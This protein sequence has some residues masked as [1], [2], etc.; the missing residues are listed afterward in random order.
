M[1]RNFAAV[2]LCLALLI[3]G[4]GQKLAPQQASDL[5][6]Q[7]RRLLRQH[8]LAGEIAPAQWPAAI[9]ALRPER[10]YVRAEGLYIRKSSFF[11]T[12]GG[13]FV[14]ASLEA[15]FGRAGD[16]AYRPIAEGVYAYRIEG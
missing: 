10:V 13:Y 11:V 9:A 14:P 16:P 6:S 12:E 1:I 5:A 7:A 4:C 3:A 15:D 8:P 2:A